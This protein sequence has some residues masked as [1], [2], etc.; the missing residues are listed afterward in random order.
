[1]NIIDVNRKVFEYKKTGNIK[2]NIFP[3]CVP[4]DV[5]LSVNDLENAFCFS[6]DERFR[7]RCFYAGCVDEDLKKVLSDV[8]EG[9]MLE[10]LY[11]NEGENPNRELIESV[12]FEHYATFI[13]RTT[14]FVSN[15]YEVPEVGRR[16]ILSE[17]YD[18]D[19]GEEAE[20]KDV[21]E[22]FALHKSTFDVQIDDVFTIDE[23]KKIIDEKNCV[24]VREDGKIVCYYVYRIEGKKLYANVSLNRGPANYLYNI[25]RR[26]FTDAWENGVRTISAWYDVKNK[27][28]LTRVNKAAEKTVK[29][30]S[31]LYN[32]IFIKC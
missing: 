6:V 32:D 29:A 30:E 27:K 25:E 7:K 15:P 10:E 4:E 5:E 24:L 1:M 9:T 23:W 13:R 22:L 3:G 16:A 21:E 18:P 19:F 12:G 28:A 14:T 31:Y 20:E 8:S 11:K 2:T 17:M 26:V